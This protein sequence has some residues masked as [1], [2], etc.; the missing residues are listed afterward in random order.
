METRLSVV[1]QFK[2]YIHS[3]C[4]VSENNLSTQTFCHML[5]IYSSS[6]AM[7]T[8]PAAFFFCGVFGRVQRYLDWFVYHMC[9][10]F[11]SCFVV[12]R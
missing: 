4:T 3:L 10:V 9:L 5:V 12:L 1:L 8:I 11:I 2:N 6:T 7:T